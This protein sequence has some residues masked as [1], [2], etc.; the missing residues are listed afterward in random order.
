METALTPTAAT[1]A[2]ARI[3]DRLSVME[4]A[5]RFYAKEYNWQSATSYMCGHGAIHCNAMADKGTK[6]RAALAA[7]KLEGV[8]EP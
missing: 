3:A 8:G 4:E 1:E 6:A 5:L 2:F 7:V